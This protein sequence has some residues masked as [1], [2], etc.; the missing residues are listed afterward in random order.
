MPSVL[1]TILLDKI[2]D[3]VQEQLAIKDTS[4]PK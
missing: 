4:F 1:Q 3:Q 2:R